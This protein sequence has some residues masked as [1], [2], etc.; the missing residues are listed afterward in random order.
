MVLY[1]FFV[2]LKKNNVDL[3]ELNNRKIFHST[4]P[5][6]IFRMRM[7]L[8]NL[9]EI[10]IIEITNKSF[11]KSWECDWKWWRVK[12]LQ[13]VVD[14]DN[15]FATRFIKKNSSHPVDVFSGYI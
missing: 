2:N 9:K 1:G 15:K 7:S 11:N 12:I 8:K 6:T 10:L 4:Q 5:F 3:C 13:D 14:M